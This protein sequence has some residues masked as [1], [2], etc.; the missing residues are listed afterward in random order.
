M[1]SYAFDSEPWS[2]WSSETVAVT[3]GLPSGNHYI[4]V[5][6]ARDVNGIPGIQPDEE[7]PS[8]AERTWVVGVGSWLLTVPKGPPI[9][10][11]RLE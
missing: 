10:L 8:P 5:K 11:W 6:S 2:A 9:K 7:D 3:E 4:R 1:F